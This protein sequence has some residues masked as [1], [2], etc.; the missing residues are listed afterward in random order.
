M[1]SR[2]GLDFNLNLER[3]IVDEHARSLP[4]KQRAAS[5]HTANVEQPSIPSLD[6]TGLSL[7]SA[8]PRGS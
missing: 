5:S 1:R 7:R 8:T 2:C 4:E 6:D 3:Q